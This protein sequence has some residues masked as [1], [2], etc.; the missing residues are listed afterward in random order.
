[1]P[2]RLFTPVDSLFIAK[3]QKIS[4]HLCPIES[5]T[6]PRSALE[7]A[8]S[9]FLALDEAQTWTLVLDESRRDGRRLQGFLQL[10]RPSPH[11]ALY[12][13]SLAP[14]LQA[15]EDGGVIWN[16]LLCHA[17]D[18]AGQKGIWRLFAAADSDSPEQELLL[19]AG[20]SAYAREDI[21]CHQPVAEVRRRGEDGI[22]PQK[23]GDRVALSSLYQSITPH[24]VQQAEFGPFEPGQT[25][26]PGPIVWNEGEGFVWQDNQGIGGYG[27]LWPGQAGHWLTLLLHPRAG[28]QG[29]QLIE[30]GMALQSYYP[31]RP[32]YCAV[33]EYQSH[34]RADLEAQGFTWLSTQCCLVRHT[35]VRIHEPAHGLVA[36]LDKR[37]E[38]PTTPLSSIQ[39]RVR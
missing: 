10:T 12:V 29:Q 6:H 2:V 31:A 37:A 7:Q 39:K 16:R 14:T 38:A 22:R 26:L 5:L 9:S 23:S 15:D 24:L 19:N 36:V 1:M 34:L 32:I 33:R 27:H 11:P 4:Q 30:Y 3:L 28:R 35:T 18:L 13:H 20:F 8:W 17:V 25:D 21:F